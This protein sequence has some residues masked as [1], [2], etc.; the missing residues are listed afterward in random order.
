VIIDLPETI[1]YAGRIITAIK[2]KGA[3]FIDEQK[4]L[5]PPILKSYQKYIGSRQISIKFTRTGDLKITTVKNHPVGGLFFENARR[6]YFNTLKLLNRKF[7]LKKQQKN[8]TN[9]SRH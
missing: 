2:I 6:E 5:F 1:I 4:K 9:P 8:Q 3:G 7:H